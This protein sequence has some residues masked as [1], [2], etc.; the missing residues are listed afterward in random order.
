MIAGARTLVA[1]EVATDAE[2][3]GKPLREEFDSIVASTDPAR[4]VQDFENHRPDVLLQ[5]F[6]T[7]EKA[8]RYYLGR[9]RLSTWSMRSRT[10]PDPRQ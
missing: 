5:A 6:N 3:V 9:Y 8:E 10:E 7:L 4:T 2:I 1:T